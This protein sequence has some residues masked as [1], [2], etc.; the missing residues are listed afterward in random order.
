ME[1]NMKKQSIFR[2]IVNSKT[3]VIL[4]IVSMA[5]FV[6]GA[7]VG[8]II[9]VNQ[10]VPFSEV[11]EITKRMISYD[12]ESII[13]LIIIGFFAI[14]TI[15]PLV[16]FVVSFIPCLIITILMWIIYAIIIWIKRELHKDV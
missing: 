11:I 16:G 7:I 13:A 8:G 4:Y 6:V 2:L 15:Y 1:E 10:V 14:S 9:T 12:L 3:S 5:I